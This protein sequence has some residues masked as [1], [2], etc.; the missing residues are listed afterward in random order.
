MKKDHSTGAMKHLQISTPAFILI[1]IIGFFQIAQ[2]QTYDYGDAP[3]SYSTLYSN[4]GARHSYDV[5]IYL[6]R[7]IDVEKDGLLSSGANGDDNNNQD[8]ED[9]VNLTGSLVK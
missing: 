6:G 4:S 3:N 7:K 9:G 2:A 1:F 5:K 8:D